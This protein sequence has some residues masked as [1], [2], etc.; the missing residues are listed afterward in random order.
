M[1]FIQDLAPDT[2]HLLERIYKRSRYPRTRQRAQCLL[3]SAEGYSVPELV[4]IFRVT[5]VTIYNWFNAWDTRRFAVSMTVR[6]REIPP[7]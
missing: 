5:S 6:A 1:R 2:I 4:R 7:N 3:L